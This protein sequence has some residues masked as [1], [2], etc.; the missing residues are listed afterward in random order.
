M[1]ESCISFCKSLAFFGPGRVD[2]VMLFRP[3][4]PKMMIL[5]TKIFL[6]AMHPSLSCPDMG[7]KLTVPA[8]TVD[9]SMVLSCVRA[10]SKGTSPGA[11]KLRA[12]SSLI[13]TSS[14]CHCST[15]VLV[16]SLL[17][18]FPNFATIF[19][20]AWRR[21]CCSSSGNLEVSNS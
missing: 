11:S 4:P 7:S 6:L 10:F 3:F 13:K 18:K 16:S 1:G 20:A 12:H 21:C 17:T 19:L 14:K 8:L 15:I 9:E 5:L 2:I